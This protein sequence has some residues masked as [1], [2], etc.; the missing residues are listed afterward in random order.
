[1]IYQASPLRAGFFLTMIMDKV[2]MNLYLDTKNALL[3][4]DVSVDYSEFVLHEHSYQ[5]G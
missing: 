1:M 3:V 4:Q 2:I 5:R